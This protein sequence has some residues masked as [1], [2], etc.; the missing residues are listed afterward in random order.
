M[1]RLIKNR[2]L[3]FFIVCFSL[4]SLLTFTAIPRKVYADDATTAVAGMLEVG[5][6]FIAPEVAV[7]ALIGAGAY[8]GYTVANAY[9]SDI[10][11]Y[12]EQQLLTLS[13]TALADY[14]ATTTDGTSD[15]L[16]LT[17][18]GDTYAKSTFSTLSSSNMTIA[19]PAPVETTD[20]NVVN[21]TAPFMCSGHYVTPYAQV[22]GKV[23]SQF[24]IKYGSTVSFYHYTNYSNKGFSTSSYTP[25]ND[26]LIRFY[27]N[28]VNAVYCDYSYNNG[29]TWNTWYSIGGLT[30]NSAY[31]FAMGYD[32]TSQTVYAPG[33]TA[34][35]TGS[36]TAIA[37]NANV[38]V[39][40][41]GQYA[42][43]GK[44]VV[45]DISGQYANGTAIGG[46]SAK[47]LSGTV[48]DTGSSTSSTSAT[49]ASTATNTGVI[50]TTVDGIKTFVGNI[51]DVVQQILDW[52]KGFVDNLI[53]ALKTLLL[54]LFIPDSSILTNEFTAVQ[55]KLQNTF[56]CNL[57][58]LTTLKNSSSS[59][60]NFIY[61]F[62]VMGVPVTLDLN[63]IKQVTPYSQMIA[64]GLVAIF[65]VWYNFRKII[66]IIRGSSP[67]GG[68][69]HVGQ[70]SGGSSPVASSVNPSASSDFR[71]GDY[72]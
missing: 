62:T 45:Y 30:I 2:Y 13:A 29:S 1:Y 51:V 63:F 24:G 56:P 21:S 38:S 64:N 7:A 12:L 59:E 40:I 19:Q 17:D 72:S 22:N 53:S 15:Y 43:D 39:P 44:T 16:S 55:S 66:W 6:A 52:L 28:N 48:S 8:A 71:S 11:T 58:L 25:T 37:S 35:S 68:D 3:K 20:N 27:Q 41:S 33:S 34:I 69:G 5:G 47:T 36:S 61:N 57:D 46:L 54:S 65:L 18:D 42:S 10:K 50:A 49:D 67:I 31:I 14:F 26:C 70:S 23:Y 32:V 60:P 9:S 4:V